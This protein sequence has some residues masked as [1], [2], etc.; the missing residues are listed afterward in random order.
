MISTEAKEKAMVIGSG[1]GFGLSVGGI[2]RVSIVGSDL[3]LIGGTIT[4]VLA[5]FGA[6]GML[7]RI[8]EGVAATG[9]G[10]MGAGIASK[11]KEINPVKAKA[12]KVA[13]KVS[14]QNTGAQ[15]MGGI[16]F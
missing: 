1:L 15:V 10:I 14:G 2:S 12:S 11:R 6:R 8:G 13:T 5:G 16:E 3:A 9:A 4:G 7:G